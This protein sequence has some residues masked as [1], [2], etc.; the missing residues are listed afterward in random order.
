M[1][2]NPGD[3]VIGELIRVQL[4]SRKCKNPTCNGFMV[5]ASR[6]ETHVAIRPDDAGIIP[7]NFF[8]TKLSGKG[9]S[10]I[11]SRHLCTVCNRVEGIRGQ[12]YPYLTYQYRD[13]YDD[14]EVRD[15]ADS[16]PYNGESGIFPVSVVHVDT[17][18]EF[19]SAS[20]GEKSAVIGS[21]RVLVEDSEDSLGKV[22][23]SV[24][25]LLQVA[26]VQEDDTLSGTEND[27][28]LADIKM[29]NSLRAVTDGA[30]VILTG[31]VPPSPATAKT[32]I[33]LN[34]DPVRRIRLSNEDVLSVAENRIITPQGLNYDINKDSA[35][36]IQYDT[37]SN[38]WRVI[39]IA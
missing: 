17:E 18:D 34:A 11:T 28:A 20:G 1:P 14:L 36:T 3:T 19:D 37:T 8:R 13:E 16:V 24:N 15:D 12:S 26:P 27:Y 38:R 23:V 5:D 9:F 25:N 33:L 31:I 4:I 22:W 2:S 6:P 21:D 29:V 7:A 10:D 30:N 32:L 39:A 35:T